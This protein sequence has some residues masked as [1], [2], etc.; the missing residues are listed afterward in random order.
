MGKILPVVHAY[1]F[2][3]PPLWQMFPPDSFPKLKALRV[4]FGG[5][6]LPAVAMKATAF[7]CEED[8]DIPKQTWK[9][10]KTLGHDST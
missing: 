2:V 5:N 6:S 3:L 8:E 4:P 10:E 7:C 9:F 1:M